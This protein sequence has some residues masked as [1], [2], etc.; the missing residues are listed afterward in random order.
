MLWPQVYLLCISDEDNAGWLAA[1]DGLHECLVI[2]ERELIDPQRIDGVWSLEDCAVR[3]VEVIDLR[4]VVLHQQRQRR[5][6]SPRVGS[7]A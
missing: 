2:V 1:V 4:V 5:D 6:H 7:T 3:R